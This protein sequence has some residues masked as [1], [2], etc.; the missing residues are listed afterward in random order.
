MKKEII[1][2]WGWLW[3][4]I[5]V[6]IP[7]ACRLSSNIAIISN[8]HSCLYLVLQFALCLCPHLQENIFTNI[9]GIE[10]KSIS[11]YLNLPFCV[12]HIWPFFEFSECTKPTQQQ[13]TN[14]FKDQP[15]LIS[16]IS[17]KHER[18]IFL[19]GIQW[20][21]RS[22]LSKVLFINTAKLVLLDRLVSTHK[23]MWNLQRLLWAFRAHLC[24]GLVM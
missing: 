4:I 21:V 18:I 7:Y 14:P 19:Y 24:V 15:F 1:N 6:K 13:V 20:M 11:F 10:I 22:N 9:P 3:E 8:Q 5:S 12:T 17:V 2:S 23:A 16:L